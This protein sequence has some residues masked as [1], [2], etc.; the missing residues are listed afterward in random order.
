[1]SKILQDKS[2][3]FQIRILAVYCLLILLSFSGAVVAIRRVLL[4]RLEARVEQALNQEIQELQLLVNGKDP[5]TAQP[6]G[7][8]VTAIFNVFLERNIPIRDE[9][10]IALLPNGFHA[11]VPSNLPQLIDR[12]SAIVEHWQ[13]IDVP[14]RGEIGKPKDRIVYLAEPIVINREVRG[15]FVVAF[16]TKNE[17]QEINEA[18]LI[19]IRV[20]IISATITSILAWIFAGKILT[21][22]RLLNR[23]ARSISEDNLE[24]RISVRGNDEVAQIST[25]FNEMLD[26]L[27]SAFVSQRQFLNDVG[28]ELRT[29]ITIIRGHLE[30]MGNTVEEQAETKAILFDE[31]DRMNRLITDL[32]LLAKSQQPDFLHLES[33]D[34]QILT[35]E[36]YAKSTAI[37]DRQWQLETLGKGEIF[38]DRQRLVQAITN[39]AQNATKYTQPEDTIAIGSA[40]EGNHVYLWVRDTGTGIAEQDRQRI[41]ERFESIANNEGVKSTGLGLSIVTAIVQAHGGKI[42]LS[43]SL[44]HGSKFTIDLPS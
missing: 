35:K 31:L 27:Q 17:R 40:I 9:Y 12:N 29:P 4:F 7:N 34:L 33:V 15:V 20:T 16:A 21:P 22:L 10:T 19:I 42:E 8:N 36:I 18:I 2:H 26:R 30:L 3:K 39:L 1:M 5:D 43:S 13:K 14:E 41:F 24:Q 23:T 37:A 32:I 28:H 44:H 11:S 25:T 6:F 38:V